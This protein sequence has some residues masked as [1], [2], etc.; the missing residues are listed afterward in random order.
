MI[1]IEFICENENMI[2]ECSITEKMKDIFS[3]FAA[4]LQIKIIS[5]YFLFEDKIINKELTLSEIAGS[6]PKDSIKILVLQAYKPKVEENQNKANIKP[7]LVKSTIN[8]E[9]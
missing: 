1:N 4:K 9:K 2:I 3:R 6:A 8:D 7:N 5:I